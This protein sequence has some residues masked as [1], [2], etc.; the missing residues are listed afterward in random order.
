MLDVAG[1]IIF[2]NFET[3]SYQN[4]RITMYHGTGFADIK[5]SEEFSSCTVG[6]DSGYVNYDFVSS[7]WAPRC[8][9]VQLLDIAKSAREYLYDN[10]HVT[11]AEFRHAHGDFDIRP[12]SVKGGVHTPVDYRAL[13]EPDVQDIY[14]LCKDNSD[15]TYLFNSLLCTALNHSMRRALNTEE[16]IFG[17]SGG[18][19]YINA[20]LFSHSRAAMKALGIPGHIR[21][22]IKSKRQRAHMPKLSSP[23]RTWDKCEGSLSGSAYRNAIHALHY[24][25]CSI[26]RYVTEILPQDGTKYDITKL[27]LS[28]PFDEK[29]ISLVEVCAAELRDFAQSFEYYL[30]AKSHVDF[31]TAEEILSLATEKDFKVAETAHARSV[32]WRLSSKLPCPPYYDSRGKAYWE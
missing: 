31:L 25:K 26:L 2:K 4:I 23:S 19:I 24:L 21:M 22:L 15:R 7:P 16:G 12:A 3:G 11:I 8:G 29:I 17:H 27:I 20:G 6:L 10:L 9:M 14:S 32:N 5:R 13:F 18:G 30:K 28:L 1:I